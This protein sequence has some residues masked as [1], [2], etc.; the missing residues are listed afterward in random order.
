MERIFCSTWQG[1]Y[2]EALL[3]LRERT[4]HK[5]TKGPRWRHRGEQ[6]L[7][8]YLI[9]SIREWQKQPAFTCH[10]LKGLNLQRP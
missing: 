2:S 10:C 9:Q 4:G 6:L 7:L 3:E 5:I 8:G 1:N